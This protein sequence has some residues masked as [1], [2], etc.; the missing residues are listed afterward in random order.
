LGFYKNL[1]NIIGIACANY[2][3]LINTDSVFL[4]IDGTLRLSI[5]GSNEKSLCAASII[6][7]AKL[8]FLISILALYASVI[9]IEFVIKSRGYRII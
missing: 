6:K 3:F 2:V 1:R 5:S 8:V 7:K 4:R 9:I